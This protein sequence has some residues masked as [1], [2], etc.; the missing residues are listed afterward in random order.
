MFIPLPTSLSRRETQLMNVVYQLG[1]A[2]AAEI[3]DRLPDPPSNSSIR[4]LLAILES[5]GHL[6]HRRES[7]RFIYRPTLS[8]EKAR[9]TVLA[10]MLNTFFDGSPQQVV[11]TL[12]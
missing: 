1:E 11:A 8:P 7:G 10:Q 2:S 3:M 12:L 5:K 4:T 6:T 9:Q